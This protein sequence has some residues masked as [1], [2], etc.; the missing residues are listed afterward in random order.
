MYE[1]SA[2]LSGI[3]KECSG[4]FKKKII[5]SGYRKT[6]V[7]TDFLLADGLQSFLFF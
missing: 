4:A 1:L 7:N 6:S 2:V 5:V 3:R